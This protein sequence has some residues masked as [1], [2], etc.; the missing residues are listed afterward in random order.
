MTPAQRYTLAGMAVVGAIICFTAAAVTC[1]TGCSSP[2][3]VPLTALQ[4]TEIAA[5]SQQE[6]ACVAESGTRA[7]ADQCISGVRA[8]WCSPG[9]PLQVQG[10]CGDAGVPS[11][12]VGPTLGAVLNRVYPEGGAPPAVS[13]PAANPSDAGGQ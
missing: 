3:P 8:Q 12:A 5:Y 4:Q 13:P 1:A 7:Q 11:V 2:Q 10:A 9:A 6:L